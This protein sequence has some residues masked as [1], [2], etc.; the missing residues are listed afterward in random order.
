[1]LGSASD[2]QALATDLAD[3][4][5]LRSGMDYRTAYR[6]V[7]RAVASVLESGGPLDLECLD[8]ACREVTGHPM[9]ETAVTID[10]ASLRDPRQLVAT[11]QEPGGCGSGSLAAE[12][13]SL[14]D[15]VAQQHAWF[16]SRRARERESLQVLRKRAQDLAT[17]AR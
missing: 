3:E 12:V 15:D 5:V 13:R 8:A 16:T 14:R 6:V 10:W 1:M 9:P 7:G 4:M 2:Q 17:P 11:R